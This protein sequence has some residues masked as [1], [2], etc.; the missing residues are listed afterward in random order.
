MARVWNWQFVEESS[1]II[2]AKSGSQ[3]NPAAVPPSSLICHWPRCRLQCIRHSNVAPPPRTSFDVRGGLSVMSPFRIDLHRKRPIIGSC[4]DALFLDLV[5]AYKLCLN[6]TVR[7]RALMPDRS[8]VEA[9]PREFVPVDF[10]DAFIR[11]HP[12]HPCCNWMR[13]RLAGRGCESGDFCRRVLSDESWIFEQVGGAN[14]D[15]PVSP[16]AIAVSVGAHPRRSPFSFDGERSCRTGVRWRRYPGNLCPS[17]SRTLLFVSIRGIR[18]LI[19]C[20]VAWP[21]AVASREI[22][23]G[24]F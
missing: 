18:V 4:A 20:A 22:F 5:I 9:V 2:T 11:V 17:I 3:A 1:R 23:A 12:W 7:R 19:G 16:V 10:A 6:N 15:E 8:E 14:G 24:E 13:S 21:A